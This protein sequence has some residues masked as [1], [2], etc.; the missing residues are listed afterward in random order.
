MRLA[1]KTAVI[2][3]AGGGI[4]RATALRFVQEGARVIIADYA[5]A[6]LAATK[7]MIVEQGGE[8]VAVVTDVTNESD[9]EKMIQAAIS[10]YGRLDILFN[11]AGIGSPQKKLADLSLEEWQKVIDVNLGGVFLGMKYALPFMVEQG[12]GAIV[13]TAS[14]FG[15]YGGSHVSPYNA[16]KGGV[17]MATRAAAVDYAP[18]NIRVNAVAP[19]LIDTGMVA[20]WKEQAPKLWDSIV[21]NH[22]L[23][24]PGKPEEVANGVLFLASDEASFITGTTLFIDGGVTVQ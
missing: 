7:E 22:L 2:T 23:K 8:A 1:N 17:V 16:S 4:G 11:N 18:F 19:G 21:K 20:N 9:V 5:E 24:R 3:G 15:F 6:S 13:N 14:M 10:H 12:G